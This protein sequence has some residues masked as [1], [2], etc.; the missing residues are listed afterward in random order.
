M[1]LTPLEELDNF[2][3]DLE[4]DDDELFDL[5]NVPSNNIRKINKP[6]KLIEQNRK[7]TKK[8]WSTNRR[9]ARKARL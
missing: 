9:K 4:D 1:T 8:Y 7:E 3:N 5:N 6:T 2:E